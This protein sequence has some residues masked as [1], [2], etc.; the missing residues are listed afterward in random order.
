MARQ[1]RWTVVAAALCG[2]VPGE[3]DV[4]KP[5]HPDVAISRYAQE[6]DFSGTILV[7][8]RES[9]VYQR[10]FGLADRA[11]D[12]PAANETRY[13]IASIT[14]AFTAVLVLQ[15]VEQGRLDLRAPIKTYL[16]TY[17]GEGA[18]R[19]TLHHLLN[20]TSGLPNVDTV[21]SYEEAAR[22]GLE[23]YQKPWTTDEIISRF[24][25]GRLVHDPGQAFDYNNGDYM[26]LGKIIERVTGR[27]YDQVLR[28]RILQ[29]LGMS[30]SGMLL[31]RGIVAGL[32]STYYQ[33]ETT[34]V[35][36]NDLPV[37]IENWYAAGAMYSTAS[38]LLRFSTALFGGQLLKPESLAL[39]LKPGLDN[40][41]YGIWVP[42]LEIGGRHF[43]AAQR[44]GSVMG[45]NCVL[46]RLL[47]EGLTI[48]ILA[49]TN[50]THID[51]FSFFIAGEF[52]K[53]H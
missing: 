50:L 53:S 25:S 4:A 12:V 9:V 18:D 31:Q 19:V 41:G 10:S 36:A 47:D 17:T 32:A 51:A 6:H 5:S 23:L 7:Q 14:K 43:R 11:F 46:L 40:Y 30:G 29:P 44:P 26:I 49:N 27:A 38:D 13:R 20:H 42:N 21:R 52:V 1:L 24:C 8:A 15:L 45:A 39:M 34:K 3:A 28:E 16:P 22:N 2:A 37:Y 33:P 48:I 35:I